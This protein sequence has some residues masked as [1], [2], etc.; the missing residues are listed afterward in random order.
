[1]VSTTL[2]L[3]RWSIKHPLDKYDKVFALYIC[4][5]IQSYLAAI[6]LNCKNLEIKTKSQRNWQKIQPVSRDATLLSSL[7]P[8]QFY[9]HLKIKSQVLEGRDDEVGIKTSVWLE[10]FCVHLFSV[11]KI[12]AY[13]VNNKIHEI[14]SLQWQRI[15][16]QTK[17]NLHSW[18]IKVLKDYQKTIN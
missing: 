5:A 18:S 3:N 6:C 12:C 7:F 2:V 11:C 16:W 9:W 8:S 4:S 1:M 15:N 13:H 17:V 14:C 10:K